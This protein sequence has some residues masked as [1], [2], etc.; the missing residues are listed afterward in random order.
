[1]ALKGQRLWDNKDSFRIQTRRRK[2]GREITNGIGKN[3]RNSREKSGRGKIVVP[4]RRGRS[5]S[6]I[7]VHGKLLKEGREKNQKTRTVVNRVHQRSVNSRRKPGKK[8]ILAPP[9]KTSPTVDG[10][11]GK[12]K[13]SPANSDRVVRK[14]CKKSEAIRR[15]PRRDPRRPKRITQTRISLSAVGKKRKNE[16]LSKGEEKD[17]RKWLTS[18]EKRESTAGQH[19]HHFFQRREKRNRAFPKG[20]GERKATVFGRRSENSMRGAVR[21]AVAARK[22]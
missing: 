22:I 18:G 2:R 11:K 12:G 15:F 7:L 19:L 16:A 13:K 1:V 8:K 9:G 14:Q 3:L 21:T 4:R 20:E 5:L 10:V 17:Q 6:S